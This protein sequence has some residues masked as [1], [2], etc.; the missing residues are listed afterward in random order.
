MAKRKD[1]SPAVSE[2]VVADNS[3]PQVAEVF[4]E[5]ATPLLDAI[6]KDDVNRAVCENAVADVLA[7]TSTPPSALPQVP[8]VIG[9]A[10]DIDAVIAKHLASSAPETPGSAKVPVS[11]SSVIRPVKLVHVIASEMYEQNPEMKRKDVIAAC[12]AAG[13]ATHTARTQYQIWAQAMRND[14]APK[15]AVPLVTGTDHMLPRGRKR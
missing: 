13:I 2:A 9:A 7:A 8:N 10:F 3:Q 5:S 15:P 4:I 12:E 14:S 6:G 1:K 11:R